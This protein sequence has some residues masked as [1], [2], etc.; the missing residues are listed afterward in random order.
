MNESIAP[1]K[2]A[3]RIPGQWKHPKELIE[4]LPAGHQFTPEALIL[5][6]KT[7]I[8]FGAARADQQFAQIFRSSC[9]QPPTDEERATVDG[10]TV[11]VFLNGPGGSMDAARTMMQ[12]G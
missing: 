6:D 12:A 1:I 3:L 11:N 4:R 2:V 10:Y 8:E 7:Q 5:P 9:R